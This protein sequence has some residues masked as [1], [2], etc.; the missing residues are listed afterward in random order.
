[1]HWAHTSI[2]IEHFQLNESES[3]GNKLRNQ[4][5]SFVPLLLRE[6]LRL[7]V[8]LRISLTYPCVKCIPLYLLY[9]SY[10]IN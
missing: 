2:A 6:S 4:S 8:Y 10:E 7:S 9:V 3:I 5:V 1:M